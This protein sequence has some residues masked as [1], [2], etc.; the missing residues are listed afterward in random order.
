M[1]TTL[2]RRGLTDWQRRALAGRGLRPAD[3]G[4][5]LNRAPAPPAPDQTDV[6]NITI[7][8][9]PAQLE[10]MLGDSKRMQAVLGKPALFGEF[11]TNYARA[12]YDRDLSIATQVKDETQRVLADFRC[13]Q[14]LKFGRVE[15]LFEALVRTDAVME[16]AARADAVIL[17]PFL[18]E[19][20]RQGMGRE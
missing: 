9:T 18:D 2:Q 20:H 17:F 15:E 10:E 14:D 7:P 5:V 3:V 8:T 13:G 12:V 6:D 4:R 1:T 11:I 19:D 16:I